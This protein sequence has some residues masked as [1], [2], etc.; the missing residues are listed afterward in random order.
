[1]PPLDPLQTTHHGV[2]GRG[3]VTRGMTGVPAIHPR[4]ALLISIATQMC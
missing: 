2:D 3:H 1:M 4:K